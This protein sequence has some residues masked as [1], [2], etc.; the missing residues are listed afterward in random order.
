MEKI[1]IDWKKIYES[2]PEGLREWFFSNEK[3]KVKR[4]DIGEAG[5]TIWFEHGGSNMTY[6][7]DLNDKALDLIFWFSEQKHIDVL[8]DING[9]GAYYYKILDQM[10]EETIEGEGEITSKKAY[11]AGIEKAFELLNK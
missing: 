6:L 8:I 9:Y 5:M 11:A 1:K 10:K 2:N 3:E 7:E 4:L